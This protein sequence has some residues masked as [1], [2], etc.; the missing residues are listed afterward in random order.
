MKSKKWACGVVTAILFVCVLTGA[1]TVIIDPFF[2]YHK[3]LKGVSYSINDEIYINDG[4]AKHFSYDAVIVGTSM[5]ENFK[6]A[7]ADAIF[8]ADFIRLSSMGEGFK[9]INDT[10]ETAIRSNPD[11]K[12]VIRSVDDAWFVTGADWVAREEYPE[13]LY[14]DKLWNDVNYLYNKDIFWKHTVGS[15]IRTIKGIPMGTFDDY[16]FGWPDQTGKENVLKIYQRPER[17]IKQVTQEETDEFFGL[18][19]SNLQQNLLGTIEQNPDITFYLFFPPCSICW[20][21]SLHQNGDQVVKR[22]IDLEEYV[23]EKLI[24]YPNVHLFSFY[25]NFELIADLDNYLDDTHYSKEINTQILKWMKAGE[26]ELTEEN[27][28]E[29][30]QKITE[31]YTSYDYDA[32]FVS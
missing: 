5:T 1:L 17:N 23:I 12:L 3:P 21:D 32:I 4:I 2:H 7:E 27:Y 20:W 24:A 26:Y 18:L 13:Y 30:I 8:N 19:E 10:L 29:Y 22:R 15:L 9:K 6:T 16:G 31:F 11:L 14:D 25:D 28:H